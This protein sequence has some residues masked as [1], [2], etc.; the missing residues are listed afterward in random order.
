MKNTNEKNVIDGLRSGEL[1]MTEDVICAVETVLML[2]QQGLECDKT[3]RGDDYFE[4]GLEFLS[5]WRDSMVDKN[6]VIE[7]SDGTKEK[8]GALARS[9]RAAIDLAP[10]KDI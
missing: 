3:E 1:Q 10:N 5:V 2:F 4:A 8:I 9:V 6:D 7:L